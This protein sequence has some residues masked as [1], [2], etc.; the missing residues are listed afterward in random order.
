MPIRNIG[1]LLE[2]IV[3]V[4]AFRLL[5]AI[6]PEGDV[7]DFANSFAMPPLSPWKEH[8]N[9]RGFTKECLDSLSTKVE[10]TGWSDYLRLMRRWAEGDTAQGPSGGLLVSMAAIDSKRPLRL[11]LNDLPDNDDQQHYPGAILQLTDLPRTAN[12]LMA[13]EI[14]LVPVICDVP[15]PTSLE[16]LKLTIAEWTSKRASAARLGFLDPNKYSIK[17]REYNQT[18]RA[19]HRSWLRLLDDN[20]EGPIV[21]LH[22]TGNPRGPVA[23]SHELYSMFRDGVECGYEVIEFRHNKYAVV[24]HIKC[25]SPTTRTLLERLERSVD[26]AWRNWYER[27][28]EDDPSPLYSTRKCVLHR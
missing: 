11:W 19:D 18:S 3:L 22:F 12:E 16:H 9:N 15:Y 27:V 13:R 14:V 7:I 8:T 20:A 25:S 4:E 23:L 1:G 5:D 21:S 6:V 17:D 10:T 24:V 2:N 26:D 28:G